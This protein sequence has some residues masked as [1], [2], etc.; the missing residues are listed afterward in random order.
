MGDGMHAASAGARSRVLGAGVATGSGAAP[1]RSVD[2]RGYQSWKH[3][4]RGGGAD[5]L[6]SAAAAGAM[7]LMVL[8]GGTMIGG[9]STSALVVVP[10]AIAQTVKPGLADA[11]LDD[12]DAVV[13]TRRKAA[14]REIERQWRAHEAV[15]GN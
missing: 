9:P 12:A 11:E 13:A 14:A 5:L 2:G 10:G 3:A 1:G 6:I 15:E 4:V 7:A 8:V